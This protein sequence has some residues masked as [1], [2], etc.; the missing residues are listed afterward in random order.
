MQYGFHTNQGFCAQ[1]AHR[2]TARAP[3]SALRPRR[4]S[5]NAATGRL[6]SYDRNRPPMFHI[7]M[8]DDGP[9]QSIRILP[10]SGNRMVVRRRPAHLGEQ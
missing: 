3:R 5:R 6:V 4:S 8:V 7:Y 10:N 9:V 1:M 2:Y